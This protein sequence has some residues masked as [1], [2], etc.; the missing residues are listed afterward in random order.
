MPIV[1]KNWNMIDIDSK[2]LRAT[3]D[4]NGHKMQSVVVMEELCELGQ[5]VSKQ[6]RGEGNHDH[7]VEEIADVLICVS[8]L[9][10]M[11]NVREPEL[12]AA[13]DQKLLRLERRNRKNLV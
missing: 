11:Y 3:I 6:I 13:V 4:R 12:Q 1:G 9:F 2:V 10:E 5:Q 7:L 8:Q